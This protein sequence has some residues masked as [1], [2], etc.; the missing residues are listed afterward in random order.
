MWRVPVTATHSTVCSWAPRPQAPSWGMHDPC[1]VTRHRKLMGWS[2]V[3]ASLTWGQLSDSPR[4]SSTIKRILNLKPER[5]KLDQWRDVCVRWNAMRGKWQ[6]KYE[7]GSCRR[8]TPGAFFS[9]YSCHYIQIWAIWKQ[10]TIQRRLHSSNVS[11]RKQSE[12]ADE[13]LLFNVI[14]FFLYLHNDL[15]G[16]METNSSER[17]MQTSVWKE[18][19]A[20]HKSGEKYRESC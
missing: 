11:H 13:V 15:T 9:L 2:Q 6:G 14:F 16:T 1:D 20:F 7:M 3:I 5:E 18:N 19:N 10:Q 4:G 8:Q 17:S 12:A